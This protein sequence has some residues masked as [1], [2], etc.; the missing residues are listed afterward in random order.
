MG[1]GSVLLSHRDKSTRNLLL[2]QQR[3]Q[4]FKDETTKREKFGSLESGHRDAEIQLQ[5]R[6]QQRQLQILEEDVHRQNY[7]NKARIRRH[8]KGNAG[9]LALAALPRS[10]AQ[11]Q[12]FY[13]RVGNSI[14]TARSLR[15]ESSFQI[16]GILHREVSGDV[17]HDLPLLHLLVRY[18]YSVAHRK[19]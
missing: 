8:H 2:L 17:G 18:P 19:V 6:P 15:L 10:E 3:R 14:G 13:T 7:Q 1:G 11:L 12:S 4:Y 16:P 9:R 5:K